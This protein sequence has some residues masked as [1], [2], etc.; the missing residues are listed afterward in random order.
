[1]LLCSSVLVVCLVV[2][3]TLAAE[4]GAGN[5]AR[6]T[7][8]LP[9]VAN[10][11]SFLSRLRGPRAQRLMDWGAVLLWAGLIFYLSSL[12]DLGVN[13]R[14]KLVPMVAHA[15]EYAVLTILLIRALGGE[16][17]GPRPGVWIAGLLALGYAVSDE[18]HQA[19]V[20]NRT[21]S[22]LDL[23][24]DALAIGAVVMAVVTRKNARPR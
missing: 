2:G 13:P 1:M 7:N 4:G 12:S 6:W 20:A 24:I 17:L 18:Y 3:G 19:F 14:T 5:S 22:I 15:V 23:L 10:S 21:S 8:R 11:E 16:K 9:A